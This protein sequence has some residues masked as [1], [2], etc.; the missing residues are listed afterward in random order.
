MLVAFVDAESYGE[1]N[2]DAAVSSIFCLSPKLSSQIRGWS[3]QN[4]TA[5]AKNQE[6]RCES[7]FLF[8]ALDVAIKPIIQAGGATNT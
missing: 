6:R 3:A 8:L 7:P 5:A 2:G 4:R 1:V